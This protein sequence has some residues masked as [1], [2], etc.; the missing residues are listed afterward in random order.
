MFGVVSNRREQGGAGRLEDQQE[1]RALIQ[2][3]DSLQ[4]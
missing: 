1:G 3:S 4:R 2:E